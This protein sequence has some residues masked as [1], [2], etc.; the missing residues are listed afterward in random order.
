ML[1]VSALVLCLPWAEAS[2]QPAIGRTLSGTELA[3]HAMSSR[4]LHLS[5]AS[6]L[7]LQPLAW[8]RLAATVD[9]APTRLSASSHLL[10]LPPTSSTACN[11]HLSVIPFKLYTAVYYMTASPAYVII[12]AE[13]A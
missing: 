7:V 8:T 4:S 10:G 12:A 9:A 2:A 5:L 1:A 6:A 3:L 13:T 11:L